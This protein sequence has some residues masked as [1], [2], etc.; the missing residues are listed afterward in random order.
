MAVFGR[1]RGLN[2]AYYRFELWRDSSGNYARLWKKTK[3]RTPEV[4]AVTPYE[5]DLGQNTLLEMVVHCDTIVCSVDHSQLISRVDPDPI[6]RGWIAVGGYGGKTVVSEVLAEPS[7]ACV[8]CDGDGYGAPGDGSCE[9]GGDWDCDDYDDEETPGGVEGPK[10][11][12]TCADGLDNDCDGLFDSD[13][14]DCR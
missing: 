14:D 9:N 1:F 8:D 13:D 3:G 2:N 5:T 12:P 7:Q 10:G 6:S 4:L 11:R